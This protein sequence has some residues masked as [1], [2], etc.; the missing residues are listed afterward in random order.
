L[1]RDDNTEERINELSPRRFAS[2]VNPTRTN[3]VPIPAREKASGPHTATSTLTSNDICP[4]NAGS[5]PSLKL[6]LMWTS[7]SLFLHQEV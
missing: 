3:P 7:M 6:R 1:R 5:A 2:Q 4:Q